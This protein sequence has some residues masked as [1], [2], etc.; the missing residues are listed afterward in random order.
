MVL[1]GA[2]AERG[3]NAASTAVLYACT[4]IPTAAWMPPPVNP[5]A[6]LLYDCKGREHELE[7]A[8]GRLHGL[9]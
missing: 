5:N 2:Y 7:V 8:R 9:G 6:L 4:L 1:G 3:G